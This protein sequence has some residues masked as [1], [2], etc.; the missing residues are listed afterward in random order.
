[1]D[2][3]DDNSLLQPIT[4]DSVIDNLLQISKEE[5]FDKNEWYDINGTDHFYK[6]TVW[7]PINVSYVAAS[8]NVG[9][10]NEQLE[11][12]IVREQQ[13]RASKTLTTEKK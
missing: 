3:F 7:I 11:D 13:L 10:K 2:Q 6:G 4:D 8:A 12:M 9:M 5:V 1:M